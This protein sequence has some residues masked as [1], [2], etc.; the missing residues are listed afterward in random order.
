M[1]EFETERKALLRG[2]DEDTI[3]LFKTC[4]AIIA[5][6]AITSIFSSKEIN[7]YDVY[8]HNIKDMQTFMAN[9]FDETGEDVELIDYPPYQLVCTSYTTRS[10]MFRLGEQKVQLI[11]FR[12]FDSIADIFESFDF[13]INMGAFDFSTNEFVMD[14][15]FLPDL[16]KRRLVFNEKTTYPIISTLRVHKYISRGYNISKKVMFQ[17]ALAVSRLEINSWEELEDQLSGFY[18]VDVKDLFNVNAEFNLSAAIDMLDEVDED[19]AC[20][21]KSQPI[22]YVSLMRQVQIQHGLESN[23]KFYKKVNFENNIMTSVV[24]TD[25]RWDLFGLNNGGKNGLFFFTSLKRAVDYHYSGSTIIEVEPC[26]GTTVSYAGCNEFVLLGDV[27]IVNMTE[28]KDIDLENDKDTNDDV[29]PVPCPPSP[30]LSPAAI[31]KRNS[32]VPW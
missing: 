10:I 13:T 9:A 15:R 4:N 11:H 21:M 22:D 12:F 5:G 3:E 18:G 23:L 29:V 2:F 32:D 30:A 26:E 14:T 7:D 25:F 1:Y 16:S 27:R 8:F 6:G 31:S 20:A 17:L 28:I 19:L 24:Y